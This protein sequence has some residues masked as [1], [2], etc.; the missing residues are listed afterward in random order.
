MKITMKFSD[1]T[2]HPLVIQS[3]SYEHA[4]KSLIKVLPRTFRLESVVIEDGET[5]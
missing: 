3:W 5:A 4:F 1:G 2:V